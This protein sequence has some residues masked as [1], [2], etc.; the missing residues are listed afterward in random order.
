MQRAEPDGFTLDKL[1]QSGNHVAEHLLL[2]EGEPV[3]QPKPISVQMYT[4]R[5]AVAADYLGTL[6]AV[7]ELGYRAVELVTLGNLTAPALRQELDTLGLAASGMHVAFDRLE[8]DTEHALREVIALGAPYVIVPYTPPERRKNA[9]AYRRLGQ[10]LNTIGRAAQQHGLQL[11]YHHHDFEFERFNNATGL[12]ILLEESD[13]TLVQAEID[14]YWAAKAG[15]DPVQLISGLTGNVPL[16]HLKDMAATAAGEFAEVGSG[17]LDFPAILAAGDA[18]GVVFYVVEQDVCQR[19]PLES[20]GMSLTY[21]RSLG[22][23]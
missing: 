7:A 9:D 17:T 5:D 18:A 1:A 14:V 10:S 15:V 11:C 12:A 4:L 23:S 2:V 21:L 22:R 6:R 3:T 20:V 16:V 19:P 8:S 13:P